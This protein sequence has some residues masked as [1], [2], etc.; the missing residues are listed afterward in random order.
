MIWLLAKGALGGALDFGSNHFPCPFI[1]GFARP[2]LVDNS[3]Y[4]IIVEMKIAAYNIMSG[5]FDGCEPAGNKPER[6][7]LLKEAIASLQADFVG[8][9][10][11]FRWKDIFT[12]KELK[13]I[14]GFKED[15]HIDMNDARV[16]KRVGIACLSNLPIRRF[17]SR[18]L[19]NRDCIKAE[20][21]CGDQT[22]NIFT[23]Y[24]DDLSEETRLNQTQALLEQ[25]DTKR[26]IIMGDFNTLRPEDIRQSKL[27]WG[28]FLKSHP[29]F[30]TR[31]DYQSYFVPASEGMLK[32]QVIPLIRSKGFVDAL[33]L[34]GF[35]PTFPT[36]LSPLSAF[37]GLK[38]DHMLHTPDLQ[39]KNV[40]VLTG[41]VFDKA[42]D[43]YP[44]VGEVS[45]RTLWSTLV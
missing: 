40:E 2:G 8:L 6:L 10:D 25:T 20:I 24:L 44:I 1:L 32:A 12:P 21:S 29:D 19:K 13:G 14:F 11:T 16:D 15:F 39:I 9:I 41:G 17:Q 7:E 30:K 35:Q 18:R 43:H 22:L 34:V 31:E 5:G 37:S 27:N 23:V 36:P 33:G 28:N 42:S 3:F 45:L 4:D 38:I 26:T